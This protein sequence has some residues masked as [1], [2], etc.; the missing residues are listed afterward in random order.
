[1]AQAFN[2]TAQINLRGPANIKS[3]A[4]DI[5]RQLGTIEGLVTFKIDAKSARSVSQLDSALKQLNRTFAQTQSSAASAANAI[6]TFHSSVGNISNVAN[7][8]SRNLQNTA[9]ATRQVGSSTS[10]AAA[11]VSSASSEM[12]QFGKQSAIAVR[13][14]LAFS[15]AAGAIY[16]V[17]SAISTGLKEF[18]AY[19]KQLVRLQQVTRQSAKGLSSLSVEITN[20]SRSLGVSSGELVTVATTLAQAGLAAKDTEKAL[21]ALA[22]TAL[23]PS[24]DNVSDT[25]E[26]SIAIMRQFSIEAKDLEKSLGSVNAVAA[27]FAVEASDL[28]GAIQRTGGVFA[29]S[30]KGVS[31]GTES[32]NEFL[33]IFTSV[34]QT[35]RESA[36]TIATGLRTIFTRIQRESTIEALREFGV[37]LTDL[38]GKF[39]GPYEAI[40][41]LSEGLSSLDPRDLRFSK[42]VEELGGFRQIGKVIPLIQQFAVAQEALGVAQAGQGSLARDAITAQLSLANQM[43]KVREQFLA[44]IRDVGGSDTFQGLAK[45]ALGFAGALIKIASTLKGVLP[46]LAVLGAGK[47]ASSATQYIGGFVSGL[48]GSSK[49]K[50][51]DQK[52]SNTKNIFGMTTT[53]STQNNE[54]LREVLILINSIQDNSSA[55]DLSTSALNNLL[56]PIDN[57]TTSLSDFNASF[58]L[59]EGPITALDVS[60]NSL[61]VSVASLTSAIRDIEMG[62]GGATLNAGGKVLGFA[63][64]GVVPGSGNGDTVPAM[65]QPG[66][67]V[68][69]KKA[70]ETIG[71]QNL[72][73]MNKYGSGGSVI[74]GSSGQQRQKFAKG[75]LAQL[76]KLSPGMQGG[77]NIPQA[78][79]TNDTLQ[80]E[81]IISNKI[82]R[83][84]ISKKDI[85][86]IAGGSQSFKKNIEDF[87]TKK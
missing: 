71:S 20:L 75:G 26:G 48:T 84:Q 70:V 23:A 13:R 61:E 16:N 56:I 45:G 59:I 64:G 18:V 44:L 69:R 76:A 74:S 30:S 85:E 31:S 29:A 15:V 33:A 60:M 3:I 43:A 37:T 83:K 34:R 52:S 21:R 38:D 66:E 77:T 62:G 35:T 28:I 73:S 58:A 42:I 17:T 22:L 25:V 80:N 12:E 41:R 86:T 50:K 6:R 47:L 10:Q 7:S 32:L 54:S 40:K 87:R 2:L 39:V 14:F 27:A 11:S 81:D 8:T 9:N 24:F 4:A 68:I 53:S 57:L 49:D 46:V 63:R 65:L 82:I 55:L 1:M 51:S 79:K 67:F 36:E 78:I 72:H 19:D 5:K